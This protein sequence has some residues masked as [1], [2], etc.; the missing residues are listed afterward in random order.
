MTA[1]VL[2]VENLNTQIFAKD[3]VLKPVDGVSFSVAPGEIVGLAGESG[4]G[5]SMTGFSILRLLDPPVRIVSGSIKFKGRDLL[6]L[7]EEE[8]RRLRG[9]RIAMIFQDPMMTLN[10]VLRIGVQL[11]ETLKAHR[12]ISDEDA[13]AQSIA[14]LSRAGVP[15]PEERL[16][17]YPHQL[18]GGLRQRVAIAISTL[19][20]PDL[21]IADEPTTALDVTVQAQILREMKKLCA[22]TG[23][24]LIWITHDLAVLAENTE[25]LMVM[26][27]G[28]LVETGPTR[29]ILQSPAHPYTA[30]L[31]RSLPGEQSAGRRLTPIPGMTPSLANLPEGCAF[32][33][34]CSK[35]DDACLKAPP[36]HNFGKERSALCVNAENPEAAL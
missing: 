31:I 4:S 19:L 6:S 13:R 33:P 16:S 3:G 7:S 20:S 2:Q 23:A 27:A 8:M 24:A 22:E 30:G 5:K 21:I 17:Q 28:K 36:L 1:P 11:T 32:R 18:S 29:E 34:R 9:D 15:A 35:A 12:E 26:Y 14:A 10:P 25:Q